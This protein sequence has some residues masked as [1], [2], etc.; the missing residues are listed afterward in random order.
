[1]KKEGWDFP[2]ALRRLA[3][4]TGVE[5][6]ARTQAQEAADESHSRLREALEAA[7]A[8]Y[9]HHLRQT[10]AGQPIVDYLHGRGVSDAA[11]D[12][13]EIGYAPSSWDAAC[14]T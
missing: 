9:R 11:L 10:S 3:E 4:R 14:C 2:E 8:F 6:P 13:F 1:M 7:A 12:S 5:L